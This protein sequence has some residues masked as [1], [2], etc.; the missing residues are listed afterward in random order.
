M[1]TPYAGNALRA[2]GLVK[3]YSSLTAVNKLSFNVRMGECFALLGPNGAGKTTTCEMLEGLITPDEGQIYVSDMS[4]TNNKE[5]ILQIIGVQ[6]QETNLYKKYTVKETLE[7]FS[8]FYN[9]T[10]PI[11]ELV[12]KLKLTDKLHTRLEHLSGGQKQRVYL[13]CS[14]VNNPQLLF[15]DEPTAGLDPQAR[16]YLWDL[17]KKLKKENKSILLTS[18]HMEEAQELADRIAIMDHGEIIAQGTLESLIQNHCKG[19]VLVFST[20]KAEKETLCSSLPWLSNIKESSDF[21]EISVDDATKKTQEL[22]R[23]ID[24]HK[25][26]LSHFSIRQSTLEDVFLN[27]TGRSIR[28]D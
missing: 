8:S 13:G 6:L 11:E 23:V 2:E 3:K 25:I 24:G 20:S 17:L 16:R 27:L 10:V 7:L 5:K 1:A 14:L 19:T 12:E 4:Y 9:K 18:H 21:F 28:D 15:L 26:N 22:M